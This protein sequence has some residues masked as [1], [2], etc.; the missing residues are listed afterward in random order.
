VRGRIKPLAADAGFAGVGRYGQDRNEKPI[1]VIMAREAGRTSIGDAGGGTRT[2]T[3]QQ[4]D[5]RF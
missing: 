4:G 2:R 3:P 1:E 5:T